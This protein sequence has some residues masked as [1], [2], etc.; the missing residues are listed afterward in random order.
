[1]QSENAGERT[2]F[3]V[4]VVGAGLGGVYA[5]YRFRQDNLEVVGLEGA[6]GVGG[7]WYHNRYPGARVDVDSV[8]YSYHFSDELL[9]EWRWS[10]RY[11]SQPELL[12]YLNFVTDRFELRK[13]FQF[14][15]WMTSATWSPVDKRWKIGTDTDRELTA[16]F[17]MMATGNL[18][19][20]RKPD[21]PGLDRFR[22]EW[23]QTSHWPER[24]IQ[25]AG[26]RIGIIGTGSSGVQ[27]IPLL[28]AE[29]SQLYVFQRTPNFS[30]PARNRPMPECL[31]KAP[32]P[33]ARAVKSML[34]TTF[35]GGTPIPG[36]VV[37]PAAEWSSE[38]QHRLLEQ[39]WQRGGQAIRGVFGDQ[40]VNQESNDIVAEFVRSKIR[41]IVGDRDVAEALC[42]FDH[43]FG[44]RRVCMDMGYYETFNRSNVSL[45]N[46]RKEPI[47]CLTEKGIQTDAKHY[48]MDLIV[49]ALG[50]H[51][52]TGA[53]DAA[54]IRNH[55]GASPTDHWKRGPRTALGLMTNGFPNLFLVTGPG[56]PS[57][58]SNMAIGNEFH[59]D[60]IADCIAYLD[61]EGFSSIE[62][63]KELVTSWS[64]EVALVAKQ[65][66]RRQVRNYM[67]HINDDDGSRVFIPY[68]GGLDR[69]AAHA[70]DIARDG[71]RGFIV[72]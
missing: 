61:R 12:A 6:P 16:R 14:N 55:L 64:E 65:L 54:Q 42:P 22:G 4:A 13:L 63:G 21:F 5:T 40:G 25:L 30:V 67:V 52:F 33:N 56:S 57:V 28:A 15:T 47:V 39:Q 46:L 11:A 9:K 36:R 31:P 17:L 69:Y 24:R 60:W 72:E 38:D 48:E 51:A 71:Y 20:A 19:L 37:K 66:L 18:S 70:T 62:P 26:R 68:A 44:T 43:A 49:F 1:L 27:A 59:I 3:D 8:D 23:V 29:A 7:V 45:V 53:I 50:F 58:L 41:S 32:Q 2:S 34:L 10:E 35:A